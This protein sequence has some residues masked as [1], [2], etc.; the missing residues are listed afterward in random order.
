MEK[1]YEIGRTPAEYE[2]EGENTTQYYLVVDSA[3]AALVAGPACDQGPE[4][5]VFHTVEG[6]DA[7]A[8]LRDW[9]RDQYRTPEV[10]DE[11][12]DLVTA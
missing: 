2:D 11:I 12:A 6:A 3:S 4:G 1:R 5:E 8:R 10:A 9:C 7:V